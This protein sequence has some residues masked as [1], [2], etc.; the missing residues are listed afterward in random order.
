MQKSNVE[1]IA[2][3][4]MMVPDLTAL[5]AHKSWVTDQPQHLLIKQK[6]LTSDVATLKLPMHACTR[7]AVY[8]TLE[9]IHFPV[10][11]ITYQ[12]HI[13]GDRKDG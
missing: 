1:S 8:S 6:P 13:H 3:E 2:A 4:P 11:M 7:T 12:S 5:L 10:E 9:K